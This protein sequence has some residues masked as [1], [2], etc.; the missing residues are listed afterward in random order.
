[1]AIQGLVDGIFRKRTKA[2][3]VLLVP[4]HTVLDSLP[5]AYIPQIHEP[6]CEQVY[7]HVFDSYSGLSGGPHAN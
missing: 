5:R 7:Q 2:W 4:P 3:E 6:P 1:M